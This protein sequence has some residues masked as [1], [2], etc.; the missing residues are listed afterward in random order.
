[1]HAISITAAGRTTTGWQS[2]PRTAPPVVLLHGVPTS[3]SLWSRLPEHLPNRRLIALDLPGYGGTPALSRP[4]IPAHLD[5]LAAAM[6]TLKLRDPV[7]LVGQDLGGLLAAEHATR[8]GA[9]SLTLTSAP[10]GL[11]WLVPR[12]TA[13]PPLHRYFYQHHAGAIYLHHGINDGERSAF[14]ALFEDIA[15][16]EGLAEY[17][18]QTALAFS[19]RALWSL[20]HRL[21]GVKT[22][23][24][25]G[26]DDTLCPPITARW[27]ARRLRG[28][29][30]F[31]DGG[32]HYVPFGCPQAY[33]AGLAGL[34]DSV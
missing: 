13:T 24:L 34:W 8:H 4:D 12:L 10:A 23:C 25:W 21:R 32:R 31:I 29:A 15:G 17:M 26:T 6:A 30:I 20:P 7:H 28:R 33:A 3:A 9:A 14:L 1:M 27:T 22:Q 16:A 11:L 18:R 2:G 5:W 19:G